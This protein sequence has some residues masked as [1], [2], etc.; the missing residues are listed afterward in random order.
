MVEFTKRSRTKSSHSVSF[1]KRA[2]RSGFESRPYRC[3]CDVVGS[4]A[5]VVVH[6]DGLG[7]GGS[8]FFGLVVIEHRK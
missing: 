7:L 2:G 4:S 8:E 5:A 6:G 1:S 3:S